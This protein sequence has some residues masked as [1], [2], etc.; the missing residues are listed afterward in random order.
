MA[1]EKPP[2]RQWTDP[3]RRG[4]ETVGCNLLVSAAAGSG[5]TSVLA[6]RCAHLV[7]DAESRCGVDELLVVTFTEAAAAEMKSRIGT[8]MRQR[9]EQ[10][11]DDPHIA[12]Q[13]AILDSAVVGTMHGFCARLLRQHFHL[14]GL[15]PEFSILDGDEAALLKREVARE[16][17]EEWFDRDDAG[18]FTRF[19]DLYGDGDDERVISLVLRLFDMLASVVDP[20]AWVEQSMGTLTEAA[21]LPLRESKL[22]RSYLAHVEAD[23]RTIRSSCAVAGTEL[24]ALGHFSAYVE[25]LREMYQIVNHWWKTLA[26]AGLSALAEVARDAEFPRLPSV[27]SKV[28]GK[29]EAGTRIREVV[30]EMKKGAWRQCL[31]F[32]E[33]EWQDG[34]R[35]TMPHARVLLELVAAFEQRYAAAK[36][37]LASLDFADLERFAL[38]VLREPESPGLHASP[39]ARAYQRQFEHVLVDEFQDINEVQQAILSLVSR[40]NDQESSNLFCVGDVKQSIYRFRLADPSLFL[41]VH[42]Q[43]RL[44]SGA[45]QVV[46][47]QQNFRSRAPLLQ[48]I[49]GVFARLMTAAA[50]DLDYDQSHAL[51]AAA[52]FPPGSDVGFAGAPVELHVVERDAGAEPQPAETPQEK[53]GSEEADAV[54][55]DPGRTRREAT[56]A[57]GRILE[58]TGRA[59]D[60]ARHVVEGSGPTALTRPIRFGDIVILLRSMRYKADEF[61]DV[62]RGAGIPVHSESRTG[63][64]E[65]TEV[66]EVLSLLAVL[67]NAQ[68]D[69]P[70][71]AV[72]RSPLMALPEAE[73]CLARIRLSRPEG[74]FH[75]AAAAFALREDE[76]L[77][78]KLRDVYATLD[79]WRKIARQRPLAE[80]L[81]SIYQESGYL[82]YCAG[83]PN[84][85]QR[86]ANLIELHERASQ[87]DTFHR[88]GLSRFL[89]F[90]EKLKADSDLG[91]ASIAS[92]A[93]DVVR[94]MSIHGAKGLEF[95]VVILP[96][97]GKGINFGDA[98][99]IVLADRREGLGLQVADPERGV[100]YPSLAWSVVRRR[101]RQQTAAE[102]LRVLYVAMTRA[103]EHLILIG[104]AGRK[105]VDGWAS[106]W[107]GHV[108]AFPAELV[109][110]GL[111]MLDWIGP[112]A[113]ANGAEHVTLAVHSHE[114]LAAWAALW[115]GSDRAARPQQS[116]VNLEPLDPPP[117]P[118]VVGDAVIERVG[119]R[120][121][122]A[123]L[124]RLPA[125]T[126]VTRLSHAGE[127]PVGVA[128]AAAGEAS[129]DALLPRLPLLSESQP[130]SATDRGNATHAL[131]EHLDFTRV[132]DRAAIDSQV[133]R[134]VDQRRL[135]P[136]EAALVDVDAV[137]WML[138]QPIG[139]LMVEHA[140]ELLREVPVFF[141]GEAAAGGAGPLDSA[142]VRGRLDVLIPVD[143]GWAIVD[144]KTDRVRGE[145]LEQRLADYTG[146][147]RLYRAALERITPAKAVRQTVVVFLDARV[148]REV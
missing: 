90:L 10:Q 60:P 61:V 67:D 122:F 114:S 131:L 73:T 89:Q 30:D 143:G 4:I 66:N 58:L 77:A 86:T 91:Q 111:S 69:I 140:E 22:G 117:G 36:V 102:E 42:E 6:E 92:S 78:A 138:Q 2:R 27:S 87:F 130:P 19:V 118:S 137:W 127:E 25:R 124:A 75:E 17:L 106:R 7:C 35:Q 23:L 135:T 108:G 53:G 145:V 126:S 142:M 3:Q 14:L 95:P 94:V 70:L 16:L 85:E 62:L 24:K 56:L 38:Q 64:F 148:C 82:A 107:G 57:A 129:L 144:Y 12:R 133:R 120:Y 134:L 79:R 21:E 13:L 33:A 80:A 37:E 59:G 52:E 110:G 65:A 72:L 83:L 128:V 81:W 44:D 8:A 43:Y 11:P 84:G 121:A 96:D 41:S 132:A 31:L 139:R 48:A 76:P 147:L 97:L 71:A 125:T 100:R 74:P 45:G 141:A 32:S 88:Q 39:V 5:K 99:G 50:A 93:E 104:T 28:P 29:E 115:A 101:L 113:A 9:H 1:S 18:P 119:M 15:D 136:S 98:Q 20:A 49:N 116:L 112:A 46:D 68:Q 51:H 123:D 40:C 47:L 54:V 55:E 109:L 34:I 146:Q 105:Q 103:K 63:Y 26:N